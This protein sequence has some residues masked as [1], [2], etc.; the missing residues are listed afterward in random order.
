MM[1]NLL[2]CDLKTFK[3]K[4]NFI[5]LGRAVETGII[6]PAMQTTLAHDYNALVIAVKENEQLRDE[7][8]AMRDILRDAI[9]LMRSTG[10]TSGWHQVANVA[11]SLVNSKL[12][13]GQGE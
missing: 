1:K 12:T 7:N 5:Q 2:W 11:E 6:A 10:V 3:E 13:T 4:A 8:Q 9:G